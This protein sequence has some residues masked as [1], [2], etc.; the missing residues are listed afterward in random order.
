MAKKRPRLTEK[1]AEIVGIYVSLSEKNKK[2]PSRSE[3]IL[4]GVSRDRIRDHFG[5]MKSL[6]DASLSHHPEIFSTID[7]VKEPHPFADFTKEAIGEIIK[8]NNFRTGTFFITAAAP[9]S[10][11]DWDEED[12][13]NGDD[14]HVVAYNLNENAFSAVQ[15]FLKRENAELVILPMPAH[16]KALKKQPRHYDPR[17]KPWMGCFATEYTFN[18]HLKA[19]EAYINPQQT[20]PLTGLK[21]LR[22]HK[23]GH[24]EGKP[25]EEIKRFK[26]SIIVA[27]SKQMMESIA[28]GN[29]SH[30]RIIHSTGA[31]TNP[32]YLRNRIGMIA[33]E[34]HKLGGLIVEIDGDVFYL[35][36]VQ[37]D[38]KDGS[39]VD[40]GIRYF[41]DGTVAQERA[42]AF[43]MGDIHPGLEN[44][45]TL[46][47][48]YELWDVIKPKRI[49]YEDFFDGG[50]I[51]H[52]TANK[53][54]TRSKRPAHFKSLEAEINMAKRV[55]Q[56]TF[57]R[58][59][60]DAIL[61]ATASNHPEHVERY[62]DEGR[63]IKDDVNFEIAHRMV[64]MALDGKDPLKEY[65]DPDNKMIWTNP[66]DDY[67][68]AGVQ[69]NSHGHLGVNGYRGSGKAG[70][71]VAYGDAMV[72]HSHT[73]NIFHDLF[74]VGHSTV[75]RHGYNIG[76]STWIPC[77]GAVYSRGEKQLFM[78]IKGRTRPI[79]Q[80]KKKR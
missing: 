29:S 79:Q 43:K 47:A 8:E 27:H 75:D 73:P 57:D 39:F 55:L 24:E 25:G 45:A 30:P 53:N 35:R 52:H 61:I 70:Q 48:W 51:S 60:K 63:Y 21:R 17:L 69:M 19:I 4:A 66:N 44:P 13:N 54:I 65:L 33:Q 42:E 20:N 67:F 2:H 6:K 28:T 76:P 22:I 40:M 26:T 64:V 31:I 18:K 41:A 59:P 38:P 7:K 46:R 16:V 49:F 11:V 37:M 23:H 58:A 71:E 5:N 9:T 74:T 78:A 62:L 15:N 50:S 77:S 68:V 10:Y 1:Q 34:D 12:T 3:L 32:A 36:Q 72:A 56:E 80:K 14:E